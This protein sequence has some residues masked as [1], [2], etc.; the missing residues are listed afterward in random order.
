MNTISNKLRVS[1][2]PNIPCKPFIVEVKNEEQALLIKETLA[3]QHLF[4]YK[5]NFIQDYSNAI[6]VEMWD[7]NS[8]GEG[9]ADGRAIENFLLEQKMNYLLMLKN[10]T[11][12]KL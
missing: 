7:E 1:H 9:N 3:N 5:N 8:D 4:S 6:T 2:F 10:K 11:N 12:A